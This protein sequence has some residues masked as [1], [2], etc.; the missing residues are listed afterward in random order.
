M[1]Q[2][3]A[4]RTGWKADLALVENKVAQIFKSRQSW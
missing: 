3:G 2:L 1:V 4:E